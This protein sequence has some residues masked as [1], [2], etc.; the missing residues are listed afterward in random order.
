MKAKNLVWLTLI[1][2]MWGSAF[3][4]IKIALSEVSPVTI[5]FLRF[6]VATPILVLYAY[7]KDGNGFRA[8]FSKNLASLI[9]MGLTGVMGYQV[10]QNIGVEYTS[11]TNSSIIISSNPIILTILSILLL[12]E[13]VNVTRALGIVIG[14]SGVLTIILTESQGLST[15][16]SN[17]IGDMLSLGG[18]LSWAVYSVVGKRSATLNN[19]TGLTGAS[20]I[21]GTIFLLPPMYLLE[22]PHLPTTVSVWLAVVALGLGPSCLAYALWNQVLSEEEASKAGVSLF[23]IPVVTTILSVVLLS[24]PFTISL[25]AGMVLVLSGV[26]IAERSRIRR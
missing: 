5:G 26:F 11:V 12:K 13:K 14:F 24:E 2:L 15:G 7:L 23:L 19:P 9:L 17:L 10:F 18:G 22:N 25:L 1:V 8:L 16:S 4:L 21:F 20:M 6:L 3:P